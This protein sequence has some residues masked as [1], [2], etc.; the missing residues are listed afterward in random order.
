MKK[1][2][3]TN[4]LVIKLMKEINNKASTGFNILMPSVKFP[5]TIFQ[6]AISFMEHK[7]KKYKK[8]L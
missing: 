8:S 1:K 7:R 2:T 3:K 6:G 5:L 4:P